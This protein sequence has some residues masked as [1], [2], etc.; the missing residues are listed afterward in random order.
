MYIYIYIYTHTYVYIE[1]YVYMSYVR[2][3][4]H[5]YIYIYTHRYILD[6]V[7]ALEVEAR[8]DLGQALAEG[9]GLVLEHL[10][11]NDNR[12]KKE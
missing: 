9:R 12:K 6:L 1:I 11:R 10:C 8:L 3:Y 7:Q 2:M 5:I 4:T